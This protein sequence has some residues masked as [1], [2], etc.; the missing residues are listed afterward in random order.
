MDRWLDELGVDLIEQY[1]VVCLDPFSNFYT[2]V[3]LLTFS[4]TTLLGSD[5]STEDADS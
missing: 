5:S 2:K 4:L 1:A 3:M